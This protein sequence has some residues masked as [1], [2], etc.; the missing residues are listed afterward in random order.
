MKL[1]I[2]SRKKTKNLIIV[3]ALLGLT[4]CL[5]TKLAA[6]TQVDVDRAQAKYPNTSLED[7]NR[8]KILYETNCKGCHKLYKPRSKNEQE[9]NKIVPIMV[10]KV[11]KKSMILDEKSQQDILRYVI[12]MGNTK[13]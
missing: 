10:R 4:S 1:S 5:A 7:L 12:T 2:F 6:P 11:N 8:G 9:W 13:K 3:I